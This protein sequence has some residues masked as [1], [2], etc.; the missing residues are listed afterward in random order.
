MTDCR[1]DELLVERG[2]VVSR[3]LAQ[4]LVMAGRVKVNGQPVL[5]ASQKVAP[6][7]QIEIVPL[8]RFVSRG[9]EKLAAA[10]EHFPVTVAGA[11]CADIGA[12]TGGF[13]DCLLQA[14][15]AKVYAIDVGYGIL[16]WKIRQDGR[17]VVMEKTNA[18]FL[19]RL[20]EPIDLVTMDASFI[21]VK[22][23]LPGIYQWY[24]AQGGQAV[25]LIKPQFE[26][27]KSE[28]NRG[29]GVIRDVQVYQR[30]L[31]G[32]L[33]FAREIGFGTRGL[34]ISPLL[35]PKGNHEFLAWLEY[36]ALENN[37]DH[38]GMILAAISGLA[39]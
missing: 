10:L 11:V 5:K 13:T 37:Q 28:V 3:Q 26:A 34:M 35:G 14:G 8:P 24:G 15:A 1:V 36:P 27:E 30:V 7:A 9:G 19:E 4:R 16:A 32:I 39:V 38:P 18:R 2:L 23:L 20:P 22:T 31:A 29:K 12:S 6:D 33:A 17:V 25:I 21:S